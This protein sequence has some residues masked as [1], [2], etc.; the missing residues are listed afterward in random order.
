[1]SALLVYV[2]LDIAKAHLDLCALTSEGP[3]RRQFSNDPKG[4]RAL[5]GW[6]RTLGSVQ[7]ICEASGGYERAPTDALHA[8]LIA[9]SVLNPRRV[10][11]FA[12]ASGRLAKTD[13]LD[14]EILAAYGQ[15]FQPPPAAAPSVAQR[16]FAELVGRRQQLLAMRKA[17][18]NRLEQSHLPAVRRGLQAHLRSLQCQLRRIEQEI[19]RLLQAQ[20]SWAQK[21]QRLSS[22]D[23]VGQTTAVTLL[24]TVPELGS[25]NRR[26]V[27]ALVGV[28]PFNRDSGGWRG[29][30]AI[31]GGRPAAR[32]ALY[33]A[34]LV[35]AFHNGVLKIFY[36]R[37]IDAGK[38]PKLAL[39]AVMRK[40]I[41][42]LNRLLKDPTFQP[43]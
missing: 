27:A 26:Q 34:A 2:G 35:A 36:Q 21:V 16:A 4:H 33:M 22:V 43:T 12:R 7:V 28:A 37:L 6:L 11:D 29:H 41:I 25:L 8:A 30:R 5:I 15:R 24:A 42:L 17:E 19:D 39:T 32:A 10:R 18:Q 31:A 23:G 14:A 9:V 20:P 13:R 40:L 38:P 1:M 3:Q